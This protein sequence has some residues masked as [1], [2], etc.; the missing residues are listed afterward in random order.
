MKILIASPEAVPFIKTGGLADVAGALCMEFRKMKKEACCI[1]PLYKKIKE[2]KTPLLNTGLIINVPVGDRVI[3]GRIFSDQLSTFFVECDE[4][5][6]RQELYGTPEGDYNDNAARFVFFSRGILEACKALGFIPDIIH[7]NDWQT[8]LI[9]LYLKTLYKDDT[10][11]RKTASLLTIHNLGYQGNFPA[12][13]MPVTNLGWE[14]FTPEGVEFYGKV[15]YLKAGIISTDILTTVSAAYAE[16]ILDKE[17][18]FGLE[19]LLRTRGDDLFGVINGIDY[20]EWDPAKDGFIPANYRYSDISGKA[21]CKRELMKS[22]FKSSGNKD[23]GRMPLIGMVGRLSEQKG[24]D[25]L[26]QSV[27]ELLSAGVRLVVLGKG[28]ESYHKRFLEISQR[29][30]D[31]V[32]ITIGFDETLAHMIY[33]GSDFFLMPSKYEPCGLG[34]LIS[35]RYGCIPIARRTGG[36]SDTIQ[37]YEPLASRGTG[38]LFSD[39]TP[40]AMQDALKRAFCVYTD[41]DKMEKMIKDGMKTDFSWKKSARRYLE[42]YNAALEKKRQ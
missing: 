15:N 41:R 12:S 28:D 31:K 5:F 14:L 20:A 7:C 38:F 23:T 2:G 33:A 10:F 8:G 29:Y 39:Y 13:D 42:L 6:D 27:P 35:L 36:L 34:Q 24:L 3:E 11:F 18:G 21:V 32:S 4:F 19:G 16:E 17:Y 25:L 30:K 40:S 26:L 22:V 1:L 9:P 37:D